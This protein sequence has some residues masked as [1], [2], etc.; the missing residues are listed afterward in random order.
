MSTF[1]DGDKQNHRTVSVSAPPPLRPL[2][3]LPPF[4]GEC[5]GYLDE[6]G[7]DHLPFFPPNSARLLRVGLNFRRV[8]HV[9]HRRRES[10]AQCIS[11]GFQEMRL[12]QHCVL[13]TVFFSG[14]QVSMGING[15]GVK[16]QSGFSTPMLSYY[17][18]LES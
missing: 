7:L 15:I 18:S 10:I 8:D 2:F 17:S 16:E 13:R 3:S 14:L 11:I 6:K 5:G 1:Y 4:K 12:T 9:R